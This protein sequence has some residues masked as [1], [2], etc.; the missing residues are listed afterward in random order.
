MKNKFFRKLLICSLFTTSPLYAAEVANTTAGVF[1][2]NE[3][4]TQT[5]QDS[6]DDVGRQVAVVIGQRIKANLPSSSTDNVQTAIA[7]SKAVDINLEKNSVNVSLKSLWEN[8]LDLGK[9]MSFIK[10]KANS[11]ITSM[12]E[13]VKVMFYNTYRG[14]LIA[15]QNRLNEAYMNQ[16]QRIAKNLGKYGGAAFT[17]SMTGLV[18]SIVNVADACEKAAANGSLSA[19]ATE[20]YKNLSTQVSNNA[21]QAITNISENVVD[22]AANAV[23]SGVNQINTTINGTINS[24]TDKAVNSVNKIFGEN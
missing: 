18:P 8:G 11:I 15:V 7:H 4:K 21:Q 10:D 9:W 24:V 13:R 1:D 22:A 17:E 20:A 12:W 5:S 16:V 6:C 3:I 2:L 14:A 23:N 19:C